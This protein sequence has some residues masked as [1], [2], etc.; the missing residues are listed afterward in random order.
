MDNL[1]TKSQSPLHS[2]AP[3]HL[4]ESPNAALLLAKASLKTGRFKAGDA[5]PPMRADWENLSIDTYHLQRYKNICGFNTQQIPATYLWVRAF[6]LIMMVLVSR[7][8]P[9][10]AMG[11]VHLRNQISVH[12]PFDVNSKFSITAAIDHSEL[13]SKGLEW[14][15]KISVLIDGQIVW[16]SR[17]TFLYRCDTGLEYKAKEKIE[18]Q[19]ECQCWDLPSNLGRRYSIIS[20]DYNPIHLSS[21]S[22]KLFGFKRAIAHGMW[23]KA[24]CLAAIE[25]GLPSSEYTVDVDFLKPVFLPSKVHF[26]SNFHSNQQQF[27][28]FSSSGKQMHLQGYIS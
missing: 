1:K 19:G 3:L 2:V 21:I 10:K 5:L 9:L 20:G 13:S 16:S 22:A 18:P 4:E 24:R 27:S 12:S 6:P 17:S 14:S 23:S 8:F 7:Q 15:M 25:E 26:Y 28:L 11:Q